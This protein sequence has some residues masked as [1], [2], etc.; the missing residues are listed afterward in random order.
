MIVDPMPKNNP[1]DCFYKPWYG[2][3]FQFAC[4]KGVF[5]LSL[6]PKKHIE[7]GYIYKAY[8]GVW[9]GKKE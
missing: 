3:V 6:G 9:C 4:K 2:F 7:W 1:S 8:I 5:S